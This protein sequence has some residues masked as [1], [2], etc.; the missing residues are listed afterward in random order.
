MKLH[1]PNSR[2]AAAA[3][4][5]A[6]LGL[7]NFANAQTSGKRS[8]K[9]AASGPAPN[10]VATTPAVG[11]TDVDPG[12]K[13]ITV[14][15]D[16]DMG[17]GM[18]WTGGGEQFPKTPEGQ[19]AQWRDKRTCVLPVLLEP[20]HAYQVGINSSSYKNFHTVGG[21]PVEPS[22]I[23]F[24]TKGS[25]ADQ[26]K[27]MIPPKIVATSPGVGAK[28]VDPGLTEITVTFDQDMGGGMSWTGGGPEFPPSPQGQKAQW[29][30]KRTCVL[31]VKLQ[32]GHR[33]RVGIN[34]PSHQ[35][36]SSDLGVAAKPSA[37]SFTTQ[38]ASGTADSKPQ[39]TSGATESK[40]QLPKIVKLSPPNGAQDVSPDLTELRV[41][42]DIPMGGGFSWC[43]DGPQFPKI[44]E[45]KRPTWID[46]GK[47]CV[48][49]VKLESG[50][51]YEI[52]LNS[53]SH[54]NFKS[55]DGVPLEP[56]LY[57]FKTSGK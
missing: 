50:V 54:K 7:V 49:P 28:D 36:F 56:V 34:S 14:T 22:T 2:L 32:A 5:L 15:F 44:Q 38:A 8:A 43:G 51:E 21:V 16:Q 35:N 39:G 12:L 17:G 31:P 48:L 41:T 6:A 20:A 42:F 53:E 24:T 10:I 4:L 47:T 9:K 30:D 57:T 40:T 19:P 45:G 13:E 1:I 37:I 55:A 33:Y 25:S 18:S 29:R 52:G 26:K 46:G 3:I 23:Y 11:A 27:Q